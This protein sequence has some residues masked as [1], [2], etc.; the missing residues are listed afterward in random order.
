[1]DWQLRN[2][3]SITG[4]GK[5]FFSKMLTLSQRTTQFPIQWV[6]ENTSTGISVPERVAD[7]W[8][9]IYFRDYEYVESQVH[10]RTYLHAIVFN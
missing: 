5:I 9:S 10:S 2:F 7:H 6:K 1:M 8:N 3:C 4:K